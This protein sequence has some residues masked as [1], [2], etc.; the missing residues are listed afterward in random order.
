MM[1]RSKVRLRDALL[2]VLVVWS[3]S[4]AAPAQE[5]VVNADKEGGLADFSIKPAVPKGTKKNEIGLRSTTVC[6]PDSIGQSAYTLKISKIIS[7]AWNQSRHAKT[8]K[9]TVSLSF[10]IKKSGD[11]SDLIVKKSSGS[12]KIDKAALKAIKGVSP[13]P[14]LPDD[15]PDSVQVEVTLGKTQ[16]RGQHYSA[17]PI[18]DYLADSTRFYTLLVSLEQT[19][20]QRAQ[21][22]HRSVVNINRLRKG[23][24]HASLTSLQKDLSN[25]TNLQ[26]GDH[27]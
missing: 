9:N 3:Y 14:A 15:A 16:E 24:R 13:L 19:L 22:S 18:V 10:S 17:Q 21:L 8:T 27:C 5:T 2:A 1:L 25:D 11:V 26:W 6:P 23:S 12:K 7:E 20:N 4:A